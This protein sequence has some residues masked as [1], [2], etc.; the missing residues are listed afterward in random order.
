[1]A[2]P[3]YFVA[4]KSI[5][6]FSWIRAGA[7]AGAGTGAGA[8]FTPKE[9]LADYQLFSILEAAG[10]EPREIDTTPMGTPRGQVHSKVSL[11]DAFCAGRTGPMVE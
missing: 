10:R 9:H 1:M 8:L 2:H 11:A 3:S 5:L 6:Q 7:G 4:V